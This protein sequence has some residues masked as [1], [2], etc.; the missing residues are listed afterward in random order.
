MTDQARIRPHLK[1]PEPRLLLGSFKPL[2]DV[3]AGKA[4][5]QDRFEPGAGRGVADEVL[6]LAGQDVPG[7]DQPVFP[8]GRTRMLLVGGIDQMDTSCLHIPEGLA[9]GHI[10]DV[11]A[12]PPLL[13]EDRAVPAHIVNPL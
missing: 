4:H 10:L 1:V 2:F 5:A 12:F 3:P 9:A 13:G 6:D 11:D 8:G 7:H